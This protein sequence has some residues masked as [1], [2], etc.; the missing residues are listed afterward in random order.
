MSVC[1]WGYSRKIHTADAKV[2]S[3]HAVPKYRL[4]QYGMGR[5][6]EWAQ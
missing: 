5:H 3:S 6:L 4:G 1:F 2:I